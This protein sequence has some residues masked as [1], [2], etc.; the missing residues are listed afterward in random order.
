MNFGY[1]SL[2][3]ITIFHYYITISN[4]MEAKLMKTTFYCVNVEFYDNYDED[5][6]VLFH[7]VKACVTESGKLGKTHMRQMPGLTAFRLW[8]VD[9]ARAKE[10]LGMIKSG[11]ADEDDIFYL[12]SMFKDD[13]LYNDFLEYEAKI[14]G[15]A[16]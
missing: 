8:W 5:G 3:R 1:K 15:A 7:E 2:D 6:N 11:E 12:Y 16:A 10:L 9:E 14:K 4:D 13:P